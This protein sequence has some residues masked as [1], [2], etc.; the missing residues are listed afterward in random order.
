MPAFVTQTEPLSKLHP[1]TL[2]RCPSLLPAKLPSIAIS[3]ISSSPSAA[4]ML[5]TLWNGRHASP[6][7]SPR[8]LGSSG[9]RR[10]SPT[11]PSFSPRPSNSASQLVSPST[12]GAQPQNPPCRPRMVSTSIAGVHRISSQPQAKKSMQLLKPRKKSSGPPIRSL[13]PS[14]VS[15]LR[16]RGRRSRA[17]MR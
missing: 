10:A 2:L 11:T 1:P 16:L 17:G 3:K 14:R 5:A 8:H 13:T 6:Q 4:C 15:F 9:V 7:Q 12:S